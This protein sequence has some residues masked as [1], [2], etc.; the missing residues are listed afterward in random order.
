MTVGNALAIRSARDS[1]FQIGVFSNRALVGSVALTFGLQLAADLPAVEA[2][3]HKGKPGGLTQ[4][5]LDR[6]A[7][8]L[9][10]L[11]ND[12][13]LSGALGREHPEILEQAK[14]LREQVEKMKEGVPDK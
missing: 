1:L 10:E 11:Q 12:K 8:I 13:W 14:A 7:E 2:E 5:K 6:I 4:S 9:D 3:L